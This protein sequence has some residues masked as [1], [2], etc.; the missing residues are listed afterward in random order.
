MHREAYMP[1][2]MIH[3]L[4]AKKLHPNAETAFYVGNL[5]P[6][7]NA[8]DVNMQREKKD[9]IHFVGVSDIEAALKEFALKAN[10][11]YL[12]GFLLHLYVD[13]K[14]NTT[15]LADFASKRQSWY[16]AYDAEDFSEWFSACKRR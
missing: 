1:G 13:W 7:A 3:L 6:D 8:L 2:H 10:N 16:S 14:W 4:V 15:C 12:K 11:D 5:T 9:K